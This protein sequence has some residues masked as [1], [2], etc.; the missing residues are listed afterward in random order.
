MSQRIRLRPSKWNRTAV[1]LNFAAVVLLMA[2]VLLALRGIIP[3]QLGVT[4]FACSGIIGL[5]AAG[6]SAIAVWRSKAWYMGMLG[7][8]GLLPV[9]VNGAVLAEFLRNPP[10]NDVTTGLHELPADMEVLPESVPQ[11]VH[12]RTLPENAG[13]DMDFP[14]KWMGIVHKAH[15]D[16]APLRIE[17]PAEQVFQSVERLVEMQK[18]WTITRNDPAEGVIE[19]ISITKLW[20]FPHDVVIR[21]RPDGNGAALVDMRS[22]SREGRVDFGANAKR[23]REFLARLK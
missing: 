8:I 13:A 7:M 10:I 18:D 17:R 5:I 16:L 15:P 12:A 23:I 20:R 22:R 11:F 6:M 19:A 4:L 9:I 14:L 2:S 1:G 3:P 21:V